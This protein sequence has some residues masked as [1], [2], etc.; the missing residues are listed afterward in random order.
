MGIERK[1]G[2]RPQSVNN[3]LTVDLVDCN[4]EVEKNLVKTAMFKNYDIHNFYT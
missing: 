3:P 2:L 4:E 1:N